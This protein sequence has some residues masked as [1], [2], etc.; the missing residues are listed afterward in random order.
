MTE[1]TRLSSLIKQLE[2]TGKY[3]VLQKI[4]PLAQSDIPPGARVGRGAYVDV[5]TTGLNSASDKIIELG[6]L[7]FD[8]DLETGEIYR[9]DE[10]YSRFQDPGIPIPAKITELTG[11]TDADVRGQQIDLIEVEKLLADVSLIIAHNASFDRPF[12]ERLHQVFRT[13][14]WACS[15]EDINWRAE[16]VSG[17]KLEYLAMFFKYFYDPHRASDDCLAGVTVLTQTL[18]RSGEIALNALLQNARRT[19]YRFEA[20]GAPFEKK[21]ILKERNYRW[22]NA[23]RVWVKN[24]PEDQYD[25]EMHW[26]Q[27]HVFP[28]GAPEPTPITAFERY[29][30]R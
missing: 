21:D 12:L 17:S 7:P 18:P 22:N 19:V 20:T 10:P 28:L 30:S 11:I 16:G 1:S 4:T 13:K 14:P 29:S 5:E 9:T 26:L 2:E 3:L 15:V 27:E 24:V 23:K 6:I 8:Y 25:A